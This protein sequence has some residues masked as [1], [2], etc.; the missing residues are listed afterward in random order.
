MIEFTYRFEDLRVFPLFN[1][2]ATGT[3]EVVDHG[4]DEDDFDIV[5][6]DAE[7]VDPD[8]LLPPRVWDD[9]FVTRELYR[10]ESDRI[11]ARVLAER[12]DRRE[13]FPYDRANYF[14]RD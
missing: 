1:I 4:G 7:L 2:R 11:W 9:L 10:Q 6:V 12:A 13:A 3:A 8:G 14:R 5:R